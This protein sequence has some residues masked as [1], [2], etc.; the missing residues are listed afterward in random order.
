M[1]TVEGVR[2]KDNRKLRTEIFF[3]SEAVKDAE[4]GDNILNTDTLKP[5]IEDYG[6][7]RKV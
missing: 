6:A 5:E 1:A 2:F 3:S 4:K 7:D